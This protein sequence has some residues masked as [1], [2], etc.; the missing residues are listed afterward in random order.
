MAQFEINILGCGSAT[1][2]LRH[3]P[4]CQVIDF[5]DNLMMIDCGEGSQ[6]QMR[7]MKLKFSRLN[8][9]FISHLH[10]DHCL[11]LPGLLST[12]SLHQRTG[13]VTVHMFQEGIDLFKPMIDFLC[14][15]RSYDLVFEPVDHNGGIVFENDSIIVEAFPLYHRVPTVGYI[16]REK[17]KSRHLK[18]DMIKFYNVPAS[19]IPDLK[20]GKDIVLPDGRLVEARHVTT[21]PSPALSYAYCSDTMFDK[22]VANAIKGVDVVYHEATYLDNEAVKARE[23]FHATASQ[24]AEIAR[25]A[26]AKMLILGHYSKMYFDEQGHLDEAQPIFENT[27]AANE[28]MKIDITKIYD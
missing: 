5:R 2:S 26:G 13:T 6:L 19:L 24:A 11:G 16:F 27:I 3:L 14:R 25:E 17:P 8:H 1:P 10:G 18:G 22:R 4:A 7:R 23:R 21:E 9:I 20:D 28:E 12:L 15:D